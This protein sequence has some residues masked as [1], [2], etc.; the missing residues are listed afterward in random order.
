MTEI[1]L[2]LPQKKNLATGYGRMEAGLIKGLTEAGVTV[3]EVSLRRPPEGGITLT[4]GWPIWGKRKALQNTRR[5]LYTMSEST[6]VSDKWVKLINT[7]YERVFV[8]CPPLV[9]I[10]R[11]SG[12]TVQVDY[13]PL[14]VDLDDIPFTE[15]KLTKPFTWLTY[16]LGDSRKG[17]DLVLMAFNRLFGGNPDHRLLIKCRDNPNWLT[18]LSDPQITLVT[19]ELPNSGWHDL[20]AQA[21]A[22]VMPSRGEGWNMPAREATLAGLPT[23]TTEWLGT[24]DANWW[25]MGLKVSALTECEFDEYEANAKGA[26]WAEPDSNELDLWMQYITKDYTSAF[27]F[28]KLGRS[29]LLDNFRWRHTGERFAEILESEG[30]EIISGVD[31]GDNYIG[32]GVDTDFHTGGVMPA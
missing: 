30:N 17:V 6:R 5:W 26:L 10:Y 4:V 19:G 24:W 28:A 22:F 20:L 21:H 16:S 14:G 29:Y 15:R 27:Q 2:F 23:I 11:D 18:G 25:G 8:P 3:N 13:V 7:Y 1:N 9:D 31:V 32:F 12:V